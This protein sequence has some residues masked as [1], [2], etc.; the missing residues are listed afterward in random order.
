MAEYEK[1]FPAYGK[2]D[3]ERSRY[4]PSF[5]DKICLCV[6]PPLIAEY[7]AVLDRPKFATYQDFSIKAKSVLANIE[8]KAMRYQPRMTL[9]LI[10]DKNDN[11]I[12]ELAD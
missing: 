2:P 11:K 12:L 6:S 10:S 5:L 4:T 1:K 7:Y 9:D 8:L 3:N